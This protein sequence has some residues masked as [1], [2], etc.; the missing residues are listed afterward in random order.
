MEERRKINRVEYEANSVIVD[1]ETQNKYYG[2]VKN[3][4]PLGLAVVVDDKTPSLLGNDVIVVAETMIMYADV[5][6]EDPPVNG[7]RTVAFSSRKFTGDVLQYL[8]EH[9]GVEISEDDEE[10]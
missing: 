4:S 7:S 6:R 8:F 2:R 10:E 3:I 1:R 5:V 9:I